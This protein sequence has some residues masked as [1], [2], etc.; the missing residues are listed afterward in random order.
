VKLPIL[1]Y[2]NPILRKKGETITEITDEIRQLAHDM[3]ETMDEGGRGI[4]LAAQQVGKALRLFVL[5]RYI[6][7]PDGKWTVS[8]P[9]VYINPKIL[10]VSEEKWVTEEG[11]L[12]IPKLNL[13]VE[14]PFRIKIESTRLDGSHV[15]EEIEG[16]NARVVLHENDHIN[17]VLYI[18]RVEEKYLR[19]VEAELKAIKKK[20]KIISY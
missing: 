12:S 3:I 20:S 8:D 19:S 17:G 13:P 4:G 1:L 7:G 9:I 16:M 5:R 18:D 10:S 6:D 11:C 15:V 14:R 2:G